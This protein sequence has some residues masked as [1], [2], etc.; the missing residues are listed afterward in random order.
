MKSRTVVRGLFRKIIANINSCSSTLFLLCCLILLT[1][2]KREVLH[3]LTES[4]ANTIVARLHTVEIEAQKTRQSDGN[5][6]IVVEEERLQEALLFL[7]RA[8]LVQ[9]SPTTSEEAEGG[10]FP[11]NSR[12][13]LSYQKGLGAEIRETLRSL[14]GVLDAKVHLYLPKQDSLFERHQ[15]SKGTGS[16]LLIVSTEA[17]IVNE[18]IAQLVAGAAGLQHEDVSVLQ[19]VEINPGPLSERPEASGL[20]EHVDLHKEHNRSSLAWITA[21]VPSK[22]LL[23][24]AAILLLLIGSYLIF[25]TYREE[26]YPRVPQSAS[27]D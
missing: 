6:S 9:S 3:D 5:W 19:T 8:R 11:K 7:A 14:P 15:V 22:P 26:T 4:Q 10:L 23:S 24:V 2:C 20:V 1:A 25:R 12:G 27:G 13:T 21:Y 18:E 16:I 17:H